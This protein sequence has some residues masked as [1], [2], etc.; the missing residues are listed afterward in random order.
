VITKGFVALAVA[1][2]AAGCGG[3]TQTAAPS[4]PTPTPSAPATTSPSGSPSA[5]P[6]PSSTPTATTVAVYFLHGEHVTPVARTARS[7]AVATEAVRALLAGPT[8]AESHEG[9]TSSIPI[10]T[11]LRSIAITG[12]T[13]VVDLSAAYGSGG[14]SLSMSTRLG[15]LVATLTQ[16]PTVRDVRLW[17]D[18][19][20]TGTLGGEGL[21]VDRPLGLADVESSLPAIL[22]DRPLPGSTV[23]SPVR[24]RGSANVFEAV[25]QIEVTDWD[26]RIVGRQIV[27]ATSGTGTRGTF[28]VTV[29]YTVDRAGH[30]ELI[31]YT[32][33]PRDGS[34]DHIGE[35]PLLVAP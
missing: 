18:G 21:V 24:V 9:L 15:Q 7:A 30:G 12:G 28:D 14:G 34:R 19:K 25:F 4:S 33:S 2:L 3:A 6:A 23:H 8:A 31:V 26:G 32:L 17:L 1:A 27:H 11:S 16:F 20:P 29:P 22:V 10:G 5:S 13:A 35:T